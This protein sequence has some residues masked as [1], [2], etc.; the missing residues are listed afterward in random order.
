MTNAERI[1]RDSI[2]VE[3]RRTWGDAFDLLGPKLQ[4]AIVMQRAFLTLAQQ[5]SDAVSD[6]AVRSLLAELWD[7]ITDKWPGV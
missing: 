1:L 2:M 3:V 6:T 5:D 4:Q 7:A